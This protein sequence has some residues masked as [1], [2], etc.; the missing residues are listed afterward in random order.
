[1]RARAEFWRPVAAERHVDLRVEVDAAGCPAVWELPSVL[2][3]I[4]DNFIANAFNASPPGTTV[5]L[6][7][8]RGAETID[9]HV[10][11]QGPGMSAAEREQ[12]FVRFW[13]GRGNLASGAGLGLAIVQR[14]A[15]AMGASV[16]LAEAASGGVDAIMR[17]DPVSSV[18]GGW[19]PEVDV[20]ADV[21]PPA[22]R[23]AADA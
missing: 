10:I 15:T 13:R 22:A 18:E 7:V 23:E 2:E 8:E 21:A 14:L 17:L 9:V 5:T 20:E 11:D 12:A 1:V 4:L 3:Q 6:R 19:L 16:E